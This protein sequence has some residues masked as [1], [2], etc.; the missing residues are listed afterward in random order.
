M[1]W[2]TESIRMH[3]RSDG[4]LVI[5]PRSDF[6]GPA[7]MEHVKVNIGIMQNE[8]G[9]KARAFLAYLP[10]Y[11]ITAEAHRYQKENMLNIPSAFVGVSFVQ[12]MIG[13]FFVRL[14]TSQRPMK[15][16]SE[17]EEAESWLLEKIADREMSE[18][19]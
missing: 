5:K 4:I 18:A 19:V 12:K 2:Y 13:N 8:I 3:L 10:S 14:K 16:F 11:Y 1:E 9:C 7:R 6:K 17:T 15:M